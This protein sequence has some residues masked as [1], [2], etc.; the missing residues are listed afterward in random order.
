MTY[1]TADRETGTFI[2]E[3]DTYE[4]AMAAIR[5]YEETDRKE[6]TYTE[7]FYNVVDEEHISMEYFDERLRAERTSAGLTQQ[8][9][10]E[11]AG[12]SKRAIEQWE[13]GSRTP[14]ELVQK[15]ILKLIEEAAKK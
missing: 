5:S 3:F 6:G 7:D 10:A 15:A 12:Y 1:Y 8:A 9:L 2:D 4:K 11:L 14:S 13:A